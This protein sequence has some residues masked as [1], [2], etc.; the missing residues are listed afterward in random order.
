MCIFVSATD[1]DLAGSFKQFRT[2]V[3]HISAYFRYDMPT[4]LKV[5]DIALQFLRA[6][7]RRDAGFHTS[8]AQSRAAM[9]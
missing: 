9:R 1:F 2:C 6:Q 8:K 4:C 7:G 3:A 5:P